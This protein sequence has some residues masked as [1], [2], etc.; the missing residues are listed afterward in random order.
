MPNTVATIDRLER[1]QRGLAQLRQLRAV[2]RGNPNHVPSGEHG[3]EFAKG[4]RGGGSSGKTAPG[5]HHARN[6]KRRKRKLEQLRQEGRVEIA[7]YR[8]QHKADRREL[9]KGQHKDWRQL[10]A[11]HRKER[12]GLVR[13]HKREKAKQARVH[14][15]ESAR[16]KTPEAVHETAVDHKREVRE[17]A[18]EHRREK[19]ELLGAQND[20]RSSHREDYVTERK[21]MRDDQRDVRREVVDKL[22]AE[23]HDEVPGKSRTGRKW[24]ERSLPDLSVTRAARLPAQ[25]RLSQRT[26]HKASEASAILA[27][28]LHRRGWTAAWK[29]GQLSGKRHLILLGDVR[30]YG[31]NWL[32]HEADGLFRSLLGRGLD[33]GLG[34]AVASAVGRFFDRARSFVKELI[35]AGAMALKGEGQLSAQE[36]AYLDQQARVQAEYLARF[37]REVRTNPPVALVEPATQTHTTVV[38][39]PPMTPGQFTARAEQYANSS[40]QAAQRGIRKTVAYQKGIAVDLVAE[41]PAGTIGVE[42]VA[43]PPG[44]G[45]NA[46]IAGAPP[47]REPIVAKWERRILGHPK[48]HHCHDCPPLAALGWQ[49]AGTLPDIG[50]SECGGLCLCTFEYRD[51]SAGQP[52]VNGKAAVAP[53][54]PTK[55]IKLEKTPN[56]KSYKLLREPTQQEI[57]A[58]VDKWLAGKPS[59]LTIKTDAG[60]VVPQRKPRI[61]PGPVP[62][63]YYRPKPTKYNSD[64]SIDWDYDE[65]AGYP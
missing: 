31:R 49:P 17:L 22:K 43:E 18:N 60:V 5:K 52:S 20:E 10:K 24:E 38:Q 26:T 41:P 46:P 14:A 42:L 40:H 53:V 37:E 64:G 29:A 47:S 13:D 2:N 3:G 39:A 65:L 58:E 19:R 61:E 4:P 55:R 23:L 12:Q 9:V 28:C 21:G 34:A 30:Q 54:R 35:I 7:S 6:V 25:A 44:G 11:V 63:G 1:A 36:V 57:Q 56:T 15:K 33:R 45:V 51:G 32:R 8:A 59:Q 62:A 27:H 50:E 48:T 16:A